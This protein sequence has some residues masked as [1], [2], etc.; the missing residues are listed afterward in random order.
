MWFKAKAKTRP[1]LDLSKL[2]LSALGRA[3]AAVSLPDLKLPA[4]KLPEE[5]RLPDVTVPR[6]SLGEIR[7]P[8]V[9]LPDVTL[10]RVALG[11]FKRQDLQLPDVTLPR[12]KP[13]ELSFKDLELKPLGRGP[14]K[15]RN[16]V[17]LSV[18]GLFGL[19]MWREFSQPENQ[20]QWNGKVLGVPYDFRPP[21]SARL[22]EAW[23]NDHAGPITPTPWG[24]G[25]TL[26]LYRLREM[27]LRN[28]QIRQ[29]AEQL[30]LVSHEEPVVAPTAS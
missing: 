29:K 4:I 20:R 11:E 9:Q 13:G 6:V 25:W 1:T 18:L 17:R 7:R 19:A 2:D 26:N 21:T 14:R 12:L 30:S 22:R 24:M 23:W 16:L 3:A 15:L 28:P 5:V 10:P 27:A 8:D